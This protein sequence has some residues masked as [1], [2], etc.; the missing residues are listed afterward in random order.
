M[1]VAIKI[2]SFPKAAAIAVAQVY[3]WLW[4]TLIKYYRRLGAIRKWQGIL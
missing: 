2:D 1:A 4:G 3:K